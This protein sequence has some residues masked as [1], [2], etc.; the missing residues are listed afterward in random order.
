MGELECMLS[1]SMASRKARE[2]GRKIENAFE[3]AAKDGKFA[4][5]SLTA[6][7]SRALGGR[8]EP[9]LPGEKAEKRGFSF[10]K[11]PPL[12]PGVTGVSPL[13]TYGTLAST[14][15]MLEDEARGPNFT[16]ADESDRELAAERLQRGATQRQRE[17]KQQVKS[18]RLRALGIAPGTPGTRTPS[19]LSLTPRTV[20]GKVTP[21]SPIGQLLH[22][23]QKLSQRGGQLRISS[24]SAQ[25][26]SSRPKSQST[27]QLQGRPAKRARCVDTAKISSPISD[28]L[29]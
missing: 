26:S 23:A 20:G 21:L 5:P 18:D 8:M 24:G 28:V 2:E 25:S 29:R 13:M 10:V 4:L 11:T 16:M 12:L 3:Q 22:R 17:A 15:K 27:T 14:P 9:A 7:I 6:P 1:A 19:S